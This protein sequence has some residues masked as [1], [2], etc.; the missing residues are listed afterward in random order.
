MRVLY[1]IGARGCGPCYRMRESVI[2]PLASEF[3]GQVVDIGRWNADM[4]R[5]T[6]R[7]RI[8]TVPAFVVEDDGEEVAREYGCIDIDSARCL[9]EGGS[10]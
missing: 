7:E 3:P 5:I 9:I 6:G 8:E 10:I 1:F 4:A 2:A